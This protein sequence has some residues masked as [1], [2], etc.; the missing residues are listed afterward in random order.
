M[1]LDLELTQKLKEY[2]RKTDHPL[3]NI[4]RSF[5]FTIKGRKAGNSESW[6]KFENF[7]EDMYSSYSEGLRLVRLDKTKEF[8]KENCIWIDSKDMQNHKLIQFEY[9]GITKTLKEWCIDLELN[10]TGVTCRYHKSN[11]YSKEEILFGKKKVPKRDLLNTKELN[12][13]QLRIRA[14]KLISAYKCKD[15]KK[16]LICD[17][18]TEYVLEN[19]TSKECIYCGTT[20][21]IGCDRLDNSLGHLKSNVVPC[22]YRCNCVRNI[23]FTHEQMIKIGKF[24]KE[25]IDN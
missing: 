9:E 16:N 1:K 2:K 10:Y 6:N 13:Q 11:G 20:E 5:R 4:F 25:Q 22:C 12:K 17:L 24:L 15:I 7:V 8:S 21:N 23:H 19:I 14:S 18:T 3:H